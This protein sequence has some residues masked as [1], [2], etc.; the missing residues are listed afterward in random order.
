MFQ[1]TLTQEEDIILQIKSAIENKD[2]AQFRKL[3]DQPITISQ[4]S[5]WNTQIIQAIPIFD[6]EETFSLILSKLTNLTTAILKINIDFHGLI[7]NGP[8]TLLEYALLKEYNNCALTLLDN[9]IDA[10][11]YL[12][13]PPIVISILNKNNNM[14]KVLLERDARIFG[15][16]DDSE[17]CEDC[18]FKVY[19]ISNIEEFLYDDDAELTNDL[20]IL[21]SNT[22]KQEP[23]IDIPYTITES[24]TEAR[25]VLINFIIGGHINFSN[26]DLDLANKFLKLALYLANYG[27]QNKILQVLKAIYHNLNE[28]PKHHIEKIFE[29]HTTDEI[30]KFIVENFQDKQYL[31]KLSTKHYN[32]QA[33]DYLISNNFYPSQELDDKSE[34]LL[35]YAAKVRSLKIVKALIDMGFPVEYENKHNKSPLHAVPN[36]KITKLLISKCKDPY[37]YVNTI[38]LDTEGSHITP[39]Y[40]AIK[41]QNF[42]VAK[43]LLSYGANINAY[44]EVRSTNSKSNVTLLFDYVTNVSAKHPWLTIKKEVEFFLSHGANIHFQDNQGNTILYSIIRNCSYYIEKLEFF[45]SKGLSPNIANHEGNTPL[46]FACSIIEK[47]HESLIKNIIELLI[48]NDAK[49]NI[50]NKNSFFPLDFAVINGHTDIIKILIENGANYYKYDT[51]EKFNL[52]YSKYPKALSIKQEFFSF[53]K[54]IEY[55]KKLYSYDLNEQEYIVSKVQKTGKEEQREFSFN[56]EEQAYIVNRVKFKGMPKFF[57]PLNSTFKPFDSI[58]ELQK[59]VATYF[60]NN[61][62]KV[63]LENII[64]SALNSLKYLKDVSMWINHNHQIK[65]YNEKVKDEFMRSEVINLLPFINAYK[66]KKYAEKVMENLF[67]RSELIKLAESIIDELEFGNG[68]AVSLM[69]FNGEAAF[70]PYNTM[71]EESYTKGGISEFYINNPKYKIPGFGIIELLSMEYSLIKKKLS[72]LNEY[73]RNDLKL[74]LNRTHN[75]L[76]LDEEKYKKII[77]RLEKTIPEDTQEKDTQENDN[78]FDLPEMVESTSV[79]V[80]GDEYNNTDQYSTNITMSGVVLD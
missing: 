47:K 6:T 31:F 13:V 78:E 40:N 66:F 50:L 32:E 75:I 3:L 79:D 55:L 68:Y 63:A 64:T 43:V 51:E 26:M 21:I 52:F 76:N 27:E 59:F 35:Y 10:N 57:E 73:V 9:Q 30:L 38:A 80:T 20:R 60:D 23:F 17:D 53:I 37:K 71:M 54:C 74:Y 5:D 44:I 24:D 41:S 56:S 34:S 25:S 8:C 72:P 18:S 7:I 58:D 14:L 33:F 42:E 12:S 39:L 69:F 22:T 16:A 77:K 61:P 1:H 15:Y 28:L 65:S 4:V 11:T 67:I 29:R 70:M 19:N 2:E 46:H 36:V 45:L 49:L 62:I 48:K